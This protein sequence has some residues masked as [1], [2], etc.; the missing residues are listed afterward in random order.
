MNIVIPGPYIEVRGTRPRDELTPFADVLTSPFAGSDQSETPAASGFGT[1]AKIVRLNHLE[2]KELSSL[3]GIRVR[4]AD[5]L[6]AVMTFSEARQIAVARSLRLPEVPM[7]WN[8]S[9]WFPFKAPS[10]LLA[11][12]WTFRYCPECLLEGYHTLLHQMPWIH[13]CAWHDVALRDDCQHCGLP[14]AVKADWLAGAN[15][16]CACSQSPLDTDLIMRAAAPEGAK[17]F[18]DNYLHWAAEERSRSTLVIPDLAGDPR[19]ALAALVEVPGPWHRRIRVVTD[20][21]ADASFDPP[22][23]LSM[24]H[25]RTLRRSERAPLPDRDG[26]VELEQVRRDRPGFLTTPKRLAPMMSAVAANLALCLP[27]K[28]LTDRE[29]SLFLAGIGIEAPESFDPADRRFSGEVSMLPPNYIG[30]RQFLNLLCVHPCVYRLVAGL[31]DAVLEGRNLFDFHAQASHQ[32]FDLLM[33]GCG[34]VLARGYADG[35]RS[36]LAVHVPELYTQPRLSPRLRQPWVLVRKDSGRLSSVRVAWVPLS[37]GVRGEA[38]VLE[39]AD[40]ANQRRHYSGRRRR[41]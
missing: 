21:R 16:E 18:T 14:V 10:S 29:M 1:L 5:D 4:R 22:P 38:A 12:G 26:L 40:Q 34:Q 3:L 11:T 15:L 31:V 24:V 25:V 41:K 7:E 17:L 2:P 9:T 30:S 27:A 8:V 32:E 33:R 28:S 6:S 39:A 35:L 23:P 36:T 19:P 13:R 20:S 37:C